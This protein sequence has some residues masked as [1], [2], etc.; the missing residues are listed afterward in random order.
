MHGD[1]MKRRSILFE[2]LSY[3]FIAIVL[4]I[5]PMDLRSQNSI[6]SWSAFDIGSAVS[7]GSNTSVGSLIGQTIIGTTQQGNTRIVS[8]F[9]FNIALIPTSVNAESK[10]ISTT[11]FGL[12]Q[13]YPNPFNPST[14]ISYQLPLNSMVTL[15]VYDVLGREIKTIVNERQSVGSHNVTFNIGDLPTGVYLYRL[16]AGT[17]S[18]TKKLLLLK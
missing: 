17:Y 9:S 13:N 4:S 11:R 12:A 7:T 15:K 16:Q 8:G 2:G 18:E 10:P 14:V 5:F 1:Y 6:I 3:I